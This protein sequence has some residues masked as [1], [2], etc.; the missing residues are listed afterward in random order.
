MVLRQCQI[1]SRAACAVAK[2][3]VSNDTGSFVR[4]RVEEEEA[5][6]S[7]MTFRAAL[8]CSVLFVAAVYSL[9]CLAATVRRCMFPGLLSLLFFLALLGYLARCADW[10]GGSDN[11]DDDLQIMS[12]SWSKGRRMTTAG[13][14]LS[15]LLPV[16]ANDMIRLAVLLFLRRLCSCLV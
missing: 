11:D 13:S 3:N 1:V 10:W 14:F 6:K 2:R 4:N 9:E 7:T 8:R 16:A 5:S 15:V 12:N